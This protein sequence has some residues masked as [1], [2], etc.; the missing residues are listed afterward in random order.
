MRSIAALT[1]LAPALTHTSALAPPLGTPPCARLACGDLF[2]VI[3]W[4]VSRD[5]VIAPYS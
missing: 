5:S 1:H 3:T 4:A 2:G